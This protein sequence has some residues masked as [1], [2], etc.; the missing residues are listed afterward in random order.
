MNHFSLANPHIRSNVNLRDPQV[1]AYESLLQHY[2]NQENDRMSLV[3]LPTGTGKTGLM[4]IAPYGIAKKRV[5][6]ITPQTI[7]KDTVLGSLDPMY[8]KNFWLSTKV[9]TGKPQLP[10]V[11]EYSKEISNGILESADI[12]ILNVHKLQERLESSLLNKVD[13][14]FFDFII[15]DEAHHSEAHTWKKAIEYFSDAKV[16]KVTGT[17]FRSDGV[18][19]EGKEIYRYNLGQAMANGYVKSLERFKYVPEKMYFTLDKKDDEFYS[20]E[21]ILKIKKDDWITRS[22]ALSPKSNISVVDRSIEMLKQ[23]KE[24]TNNNPHKIVAVACSIEHALQ[25]KDIYEKRSMRVAIVHSKMDKSSLNDEFDKIERHEVDVVVNVALLGEGYDHKFLSI[26]AIFRPFKSDLPYQQFIGRVL[27]TISISDGYNINEEDNIAQVVHHQELNLD[28][29]WDNYKNEIRKSDVI[30]EIKKLARKEKALKPTTP[31]EDLDFGNTEESNEYLTDADAFMD[32][33][34]LNLR[35]TKLKE[36][37]ERI[38]KLMNDFGINEELAINLSRQMNVEDNAKT[39][40]L[41]RPDLYQKNLR[42]MLDSKIREEIVPDIITYFNL[43]LAGTE[44]T[45]LRHEFIANPN[46]K[47]YDNKDNNGATLAKYLNMSLRNFNRKNR[48]EWELDDYERAI[49][50]VDTYSEYVVQT[51]KHHFKEK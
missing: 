27:R 42:S 3:V 37:Q 46:Q 28:A 17:P 51:L 24:K 25:L 47:P 49:K 29:L 26:A 16:L 13:S 50:Q 45:E 12:V 31:L 34:L 43:D 11:I 15:I 48:K 36:E 18:Q 2:S 44:I 20:L 14:T 30:K 32:T 5:L 10:T 7:V 33:E 39:E 23:K 41:L 19:I 40:R 22:V 6:I 4:A 21:E 9:F 8:P 38:Q 1:F 35:E